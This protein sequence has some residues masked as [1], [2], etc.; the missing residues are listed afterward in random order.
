M[1]RRVPWFVAAGVVAVIVTLPCASR[2]L[3]EEAPNIEFAYT[4][5]MSTNLWARSWFGR[6]FTRVITA[7]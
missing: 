7:F 6:P 5:V 3:S 2:A 1:R 4:L